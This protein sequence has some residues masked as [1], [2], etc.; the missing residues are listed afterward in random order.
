MNT[1]THIPLGKVTQINPPLRPFSAL[2]DELVDFLPMSAVEAEHSIAEA[3]ENRL[4]GDVQ[5]GYTNFIDGDVLLA[6][7]TPCFENGKIAQVRIKSRCG[8]GSTEF[9]VLRS[10][11]EKLDSRYLVHFLRRDQI[12]Y[13]GERKMTG[14]AGQRRVPKHF[15]ES[16]LIPLPSLPE[17]RRIAS[18]LDQADALRAKRREALAQLDSLTQSIFIEMFGDPITNPK[19]WEKEKLGALLRIRRGGSPRPI[20]QFLGGSINWVKIGDAT[21]GDDIYISKCADKIIEAG[22]NK[23]VFLKAGS[24][25]FAN[26]GVSLG[27]ARILKIDGCIHDGWLSMEEIPEDKLNKLFL[28][29]ALNAVTTRFRKMA[30]DGTQP[31]LNTDLM[32]N[33][34]MILPPVVLQ[35]KFAD[36]LERIEKLKHNQ[37]NALKDVDELFASLQHRAFRGEL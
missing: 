19:S 24:L 8:F 13:D 34:E 28:L 3:T 18:I 12:R 10:N 31:N 37:L 22:L 1:Q 7:I 16:L 11:P 25:I 15:L 32:K 27:F 21:K 35:Q 33:F 9:H 36:G 5:K 14:S 17:Q 2:Q 29:K 23:T 4:Y 26:C 30:P 20:D 6:K